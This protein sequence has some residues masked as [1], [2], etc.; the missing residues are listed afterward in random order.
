MFMEGLNL[1]GIKKK[2]QDVCKILPLTYNFPEIRFCQF[3]EICSRKSSR[4]FRS[5]GCESAFCRKHFSEME[6]NY[7]Y[8]D[9]GKN[10]ALQKK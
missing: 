1:V 6:K 8:I 7:C 4:R 3:D 5:E 10:Q 2:E 9:V